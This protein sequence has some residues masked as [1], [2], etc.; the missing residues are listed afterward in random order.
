VTLPYGYK[1]IKVANNSNGADAPNNNV[2]EAGQ[3]AKETQDTLNLKASNKWVVLDNVEDDTIKFGHKLSPT[4]AKEYLTNPNVTKFGDS[5][6][7]LK[8]TTD[9]AGHIIAVDEETVNI[10]KGSLND[11]TAT[12]SSVLTG[13]S[14]DDETGAIT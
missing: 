13:I 10:P 8:F 2:A 14:M 7:I 5:F 6:K 4:Q 9:E 3:S 12:S 11:L 1:I